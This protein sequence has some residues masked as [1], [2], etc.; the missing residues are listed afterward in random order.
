M[1]GYQRIQGPA[2]TEATLS[3]APEERREEVLQMDP[4]E[5][6]RL[7]VLSQNLMQ[8]AER[9]TELWQELETLKATL[10]QSAIEELREAGLPTGLWQELETLNA[11]L[12]QS[13]IEE[14]RLMEL[15]TQIQRKVSQK[16]EQVRKRAKSIVAKV[17][18]E[19]WTLLNAALRSM[20]P[21]DL[22]Q[23]ELSQEFEQVRERV[24]RDVSELWQVLKELDETLSCAP[25]EQREEGEMDPE[26]PWLLKL[27]RGHLRKAERGRRVVAE[28]LRELKATPPREERLIELLQ[29]FTQVARKI[30]WRVFEE[31]S[32]ALGSLD[33]ML[34]PH[35]LEVRQKWLSKTR[36][37]RLCVL[38]WSC[39]QAVETPER[40][41]VEFSR[42][43]DAFET[44]MPR[45]REVGHPAGQLLS[46]LS[47]LLSRV[48]ESATRV[49]NFIAEYFRHLETL[50]EI[51]GATRIPSATEEERQMN[52]AGQRPRKL[53]ERFKL[54]AESARNAE[55]DVTNFWREFE[56]FEATLPSI[57][58]ELQK[59]LSRM[60]PDNPRLCNLSK[61]LTRAAE[62]LER[63]ERIKRVEREFAEFVRKQLKIPEKDRRQVALPST[64]QDGLSWLNELSQRYERLE[65]R[66]ERVERVE[67]GVT[68]FV[69]YLN[70]MRIPGRQRRAT[71]MDLN[72]TRRAATRVIAEL[73]A[74]GRDTRARC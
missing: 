74:G 14:L 59:C 19:L 47:S 67:R 18:Q 31:F 37:E 58:E 3:C 17:L 62:S 2:T 68:E 57:R 36:E 8:A 10:K 52:P 61:I 42:A 66:A 44:L 29:E 35:V 49:E 23:I 6:L 12:K 24:E 46:E 54:L 7:R 73:N 33:E 1:G 50:V 22:R 53:S 26:D 32:R 39:K 20:N 70:A 69:R 45:V 4:E 60:V 16:F 72:G 11:T 34:Q 56:K 21:D 65:K 51:P 25:E 41:L 64:P 30:P 38:P 13:D 43:L 15:S 9:V 48:A 71:N 63:V 40:F 27:L 28:F 5:Q 55:R